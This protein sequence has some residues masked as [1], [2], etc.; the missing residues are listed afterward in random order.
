MFLSPADSQ[1]RRGSSFHTST[2][3]TS[4]TV[5]IKQR[6]SSYTDGEELTQWGQQLCLIFSFSFTRFN[7]RE[8]EWALQLSGK[9]SWDG[10]GLRP[11]EIWDGLW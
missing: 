8:K 10:G 11:Y 7:H 3:S 2:L 5:W 1:G 9:I 4:L 6:P